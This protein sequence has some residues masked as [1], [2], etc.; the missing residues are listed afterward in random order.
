MHLKVLGLILSGFCVA[1]P[2]FPNFT[3]Y[4][5]HLFTIHTEKSY[6]CH[7][8]THS[9]RCTRLRQHAQML[10][11]VNEGKEKKGGGTKESGEA[12]VLQKQILHV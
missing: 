3:L 6:R 5:F 9:H 7:L 2:F 11:G 8:S 4:I 12:E 10:I 1:Y